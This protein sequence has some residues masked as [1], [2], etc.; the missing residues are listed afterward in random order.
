MKK[1]GYV[2]VSSKDQNP[3]RQIL[4]MQEEKISLKNT[5][6]DKMSGKDFS[7]PEYMNMLRRIKRG[8]MLVIKSIDR[9]GRNYTEIL[10]EY[11][12]T[13]KLPFK[14]KE[15]DPARNIRSYDPV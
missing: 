13:R 14:K 7:R 11:H 12:R 10:E 6:I 1:F 15:T 4:A 5:Y 8:D 2:R 3:E 9:L